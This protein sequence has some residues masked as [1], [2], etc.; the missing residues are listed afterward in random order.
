MWEAWIFTPTA[1][2]RH[3][4]SPHWGW[5]CLWRVRTLTTTQQGRVSPSR[6]LLSIPTHTSG[7][8]GTVMRY[9]YLSQ[10]RKVLMQTTLSW[11]SHPCSTV[12]M[13]SLT[14]WCQWRPSGDSVL[15][16]LPGHNEVGPT[17][18]CWS[19]VRFKANPEPHNIWPNMFRF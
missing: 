8:I 5:R 18:P 16:F 15:L 2:L 11:N 3:P 4:S 9:S 12:M 14:L 17:S 1:S 19:I 6:P 7:A 13:V 10:P